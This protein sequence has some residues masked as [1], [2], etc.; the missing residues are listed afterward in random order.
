M[1]Y[2]KRLEMRA[3]KSFGPRKIVINFDKG[4]TVITGPNGSGKSNILDAIRFVTGDLSARSLRTDKMAGV[5]FDSVQGKGPPSK[6]TVTL[7]LDNSDRRIPVDTG[8]VTIARRVDR[9][10]KSEYSLNGRT[11]SRGHLID[12][13]RMAGIASSG[14]SIIMQGTITRLADVTSEERRRA[15]EDLTGIAEYD[16]KKT[17]ARAQL[18]QAD[19]NLR[20]ASAR[21]GDIQARIERLE[22]ERNDALRYNFIRKEMNK[23]QADRIS[24]KLLDLEDEKT[25]LTEKFKQ[26]SEEAELLRLQYDQLL[27][28]RNRVESERRKFDAEIVDKGN[29]RLVAVQVAMGDLTANIASFKMEIDSGEISLNGFRKIYE[30]KIHRLEVLEQKIRESQQSNVEKKSERY[31]LREVL[32]EKN[33]SYSELSSKLEGMKQN[34]EED[35]AEQK[36]I[37][38]TLNAFR[39]KIL[40]LNTQLQGCRMRDKTLADNLH[41]MQERRENYEITLTGLQQ[42]FVELQKLQQ[43]EQVSFKSL[44][45]SCDKNVSNGRALVVDLAEAEKTVKMARRVVVEFET[46]KN[47]AERITPEEFVIRKIEEMGRVGALPGIIGRLEALV[48]IRSKYQ[49]AVEAASAGWLKSIVVEDVESALRCVES[50]KKL[51]LGKM[52]LIPMREIKDSGVVATPNI[53]GVI[54]SAASLVYTETKYLPAVNFIFGDTFVTSGEKSAFLAA[55][56]GYRAVDLNGDLYDARGGIIGGYYRE[57]IDLLSLF[58]SDKSISDLSTSVTS[59]EHVLEK[60]GADVTFLDDELNRLTEERIRRSEALKSIEREFKTIGVNISRTRQNIALLDKR[61]RSSRKNYEQVEALIDKYQSERDD[62]KKQY[63]ELFSKRETSDLQVNADDIVEIEDEKTRFEAEIIDL[64]KEF[65]SIENGIAFL[66][67]SLTD[68]LTPEFESIRT[69]IETLE[70][71]NSNF[72]EKIVSAQTNLGE[73]NGELLELEKS[74]EELST[75]LSSVRDTRKEFEEQ[76]D[77]INAQLTQIDQENHRMND[78]IQQLHLEIQRNELASKRFEEELLGLGHERR[79]DIDVTKVKRIETSIDPMRIELEHIGSVNQLAISQYEDQKDN[80]KQLSLRQNELENEKRSIMAFIDEIEGR[81]KE[82]FMQAL[83]S[84][85]E[86]FTKFFSKLTGGGEGYLHLQNVEDPFAGGVDIFVQFPGKTTRLI[87]GASGGEK[88]VAAVSFIFAVQS[89]FPAPFYVFD[90]IA[91]HLDPYNTERLA[92]LLKEQSATSQWIIM[93]LKDVIMDRA[94]KLFG[95]Y[96]QDGVSRIV[97]AKIAEATA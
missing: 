30:D 5:I 46:Q 93:T 79:Y 60:R 89:L 7:H 55:R 88:S 20:I 16:A 61:I 69:D 52:R 47:M 25:D 58:P 27:D 80:Y 75:A 17:E 68:I 9:T 31:R 44:S 97:T 32:D 84:M 83:T 41:M 77:E 24:Y 51:K 38:D 8:T 22:E 15:I 62:L 54:G 59:L 2:L 19:M 45:Q 11:V 63:S 64:N 3:F 70:K 49:K 35:T 36:R 81:K 18:Q 34:V 40:G 12:I 91:A 28:E 71:Q 87:A 21:I 65:V 33:A 92:D 13:L 94:E 67:S 78:Q 6:A 57:S 95:V 29:E 39:R 85:N 74:K 10:G 86:N 96:V 72:Q 4:F 37:E 53:E 1:V 76:L 73:A 43:N 14:Y 42:H 56:A 82:A 48:K 90:E 50:L 26:R 66:D 23:L